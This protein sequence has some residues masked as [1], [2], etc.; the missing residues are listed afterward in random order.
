MVLPPLLDCIPNI[1]HTL[2]ADDVM[3]W[4]TTGSDGQIEEAFQQAVETMAEYA[5]RVGLK[6]AGEKSELLLMR[7]PDYRK[8]KHSPP[9]TIAIKID[10]YEITVVKHMHVLGL[11]VQA[12]RS[13]SVALGGLTVTVTQTTRR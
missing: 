1:R 3:V 13:N 7:P 5:A 8:T 11:H 10:G 6:C 9:P 12:G 4:T 2:Y